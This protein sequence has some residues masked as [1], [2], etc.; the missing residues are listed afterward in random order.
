[1]GGFIHEKR[2]AAGADFFRQVFKRIFDI[3]N[4]GDCA[5]V[6]GLTWGLPG[7]FI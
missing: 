2:E 4:A 1:M 5:G 7:F 6:D 3:V